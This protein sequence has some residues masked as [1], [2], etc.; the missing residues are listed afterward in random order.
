[1]TSR[2]LAVL[3][4]AICIG[5]VGMTQVGRT[6]SVSS[7]PAFFVTH[8]WAFEDATE[9]EIAQLSSG[10]AS[11]MLG[12]V[13]YPLWG[14]FSVGVMSSVWH[15]SG[16]PANANQ[17]FELSALLSG[18]PS[19]RISPNSTSEWSLFAAVHQG[20]FIHYRQ[21]A[22]ES[23]ISGDFSHRS[24]RGF[25]LGLTLPTTQIAGLEIGAGAVYERMQFP[26]SSGLQPTNYH[27]TAEGFSLNRLSL[28]I[29][30]SFRF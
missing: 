25:S 17:H 19:L 14:P 28:G 21:D 1:M 24:S 23:T 20:I 13:D 12:I 18:G 7:Q 8:G 2:P 10:A 4:I 27:Q 11:G 15:H 22:N 6:E 26:H 5:F 3:I 30:F 16:V 9:G 29:D